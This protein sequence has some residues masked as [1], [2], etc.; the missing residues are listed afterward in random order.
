MIPHH[1]P[2]GSGSVRMAPYVEC[3]S[4]NSVLFYNFFWFFK[5]WLTNRWKKKWFLFPKDAKKIIFL[6]NL[7]IISLVA[8]HKWC[9]LN[10][11]ILWSTL[12]PSYTENKPKSSFCYPYSS[13]FAMTSVI[14]DPNFPYEF[15]PKN[16]GKICCS[17]YTL[18]TLLLQ[19]YL[20]STRNYNWLS[21]DFFKVMLIRF[22]ID[23]IEI[24]PG[25]YSLGYF[26]KPF[27]L[28]IWCLLWYLYLI[29]WVFLDIQGSKF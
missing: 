24:E 15:P 12:L 23:F 1:F 9:H 5:T 27:E 3:K 10:F 26:L 13:P 19:Y 2:Q 28:P 7:E 22:A 21:M 20:D 17:Q 11:Q 6:L 25:K 8:I 16:C 14:D 18:F 4:R 29:L